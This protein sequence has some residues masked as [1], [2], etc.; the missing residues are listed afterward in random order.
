MEEQNVWTGLLR[1]CQENLATDARA[2][3]YLRENGITGMEGAVL[4]RAGVAEEGLWE[5]LSKEEREEL[6]A[7]GLRAL[8]NPCGLLIPTFDPREPE[9]PIGLVR[10]N[11]AQNK[12]AFVTERTGVGCSTDCASHARLVLADAPLLALRLIQAGVRGVLLVEAPSVLGPLLDWLASREL[13]LASYKPQGLE[14]LKAAVNARADYLQSVLVPY[15]I[16]HMSAASWKV[17][18]VH[19]DK[20]QE[21]QPAPEPSLLR[22]VVAFGQSRIAAGEGLKLLREYGADHADLIEAYGVGFLPA[23]YQSAM[24]T[25]ARKVLSTRIEGNSLILPAF[26]EAGNIVDVYSLREPSQRRSILS[27]HA[28]PQGLIAPKI[29]SAC[30]DVFVTDSF[31]IAAKLFQEGHANT[32]LLRGVDDARNN[33]RRL[34]LSGVQSARVMARR[35]GAEMTAVLEAAGITAAQEAELSI[36]ERKVESCSSTQ[37][38]RIG[39]TLQRVAIDRET[40]QAQF[41]AGDASYTVEAP[42]QARTKLLVRL[43]CAG[44]IALDKFDVAVEAQRKRF[45]AN[46]ALKVHLRAET[47]D[48]HLV[49][50][51]DALHVWRESLRGST[52]TAHAVGSTPEESTQALELLKR[53]DLLACL[54]ADLEN[55]GWVGEEQTK[56]LLYLVSISRKLSAPLSA[57]LLASSGAG[58][59]KSIETIA[60][61]TP[62]E[63]QVHVSRVTDSALYYQDK[64]ALR[65]KLLIVDEADALT[66]EVLVSLRVLQSRGALSQSHVLRDALTG[67]TSTHYVETRGPVAV[68]TSTAGRLEEQMLSRCFEIG[69]DESPE[70]TARILEAQ[71]RLRADRRYQGQNGSRSAIVRRHQALQRQLECLPVVVPFADRIQFP[72]TSLKHRREQERFLNLIEASALLH[73]H[74]R[75]RETLDG[76]EVL[77]VADVRDY[78]IA[79]QLAAGFVARS[80]DELSPLAREVLALIQSARMETFDINDLHALRPKWTRHRF[81]SALEE[82]L[83]LDVIATGKRSRPRR[84]TLSEP[85]AKLMA[86]PALRL[87]PSGELAGFGETPFTNSKPV[88]A[89][90]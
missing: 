59:S 36:T 56:R 47:I 61:L 13:V 67:T 57:A 60:E 85:A 83:R 87:L 90:A 76:G 89:M 72:A 84:Y 69:I 8:A 19:V 1:R 22:D 23:G 75:E 20:S 74:Q 10:Q 18:G 55:L 46:A 53:E 82:L 28:Q 52:K 81:R 24:N 32:I 7:C 64:D 70:Q 62:P 44:R 45:A 39:G 66:P 29:A 63:D 11:Y 12:H 15:G 71:R 4:F 43:E 77:L 34:V 54:A 50:I 48:A 51:L 78:E 9:K 88:A 58:K 16:Q 79:V 25:H 68:L 2:G 86:A 40:E 65:H 33:A 3:A 17:L 35:H 21:P 80:S 41:K 37:P 31:R 38:A 27:V 49:G 6:D 14:A 26:D 5:R 30:A 42:L 73:Q